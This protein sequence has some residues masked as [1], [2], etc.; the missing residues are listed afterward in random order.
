MLDDLFIPHPPAGDSSNRIP[1]TGWV[2]TAIAAGS[3]ASVAGLSVLGNASTATATPLAIAATASSQF[4]FTNAAFTTIVWGTISTFLDSAVSSTVG[5]TLIRG[6]STWIA[7]TPSAGAM[8]LLNTLLPSNVASASDTTSLT[9]SYALYKIILE[10]VVGS[11]AALLK[12]QVATSGTSFITTSYL[13]IGH[14][15]VNGTVGF[16]SST[17]DIPM[18]EFAISTSV[19]YGFSGEL[20]ISNPSGT[21]TRKQVVGQGGYLDNGALGTP[22]LAITHFFGFWNGGNSPVTG[23]NF[24]FSSGNIQT[25]VIKI[26]GMT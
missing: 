15:S 12:M 22:S 25:G 13:S 20:M 1:T 7:T 8:V 21:T 11:A 4:A 18:T 16:Y 26:Y 14:E 3:L 6:A 23:V 24:V 19:N 5:V 17:V 9:S 2:G 10:N